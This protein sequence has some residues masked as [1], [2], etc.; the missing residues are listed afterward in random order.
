[1]KSHNF[2]EEAIHSLSRIFTHVKSS[3]VSYHGE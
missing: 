2:L 1:M 3:E